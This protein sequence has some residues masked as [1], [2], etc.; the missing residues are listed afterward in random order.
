MGKLRYT[1]RECEFLWRGADL[2]LTICFKLY[3]LECVVQIAA[4]G[5]STLANEGNGKQ[6]CFKR[7]VV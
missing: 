5:K 6:Q 4:G 1:A 3:L 7:N 2:V